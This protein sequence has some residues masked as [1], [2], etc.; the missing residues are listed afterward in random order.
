[1]PI[2][3]HGA[4]SPQFAP[5]MGSVYGD[6]QIVP[7]ATWNFVY[8]TPHITYVVQPED[9][10]GSVAKALY[11]ANTPENRNS[12]RNMGFKTGAILNV[13]VQNKL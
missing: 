6:A 7:V 4:T 11:G 12:L 9:T 8:Q 2:P 10:L 5:K 1:M 3:Y 13:P